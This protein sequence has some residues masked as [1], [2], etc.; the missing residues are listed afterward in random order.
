MVRIA[1]KD[2][3]VQV[4]VGGKTVEPTHYRYEAGTIRL[5][6][7]NSTENLPVEIHF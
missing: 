7:P 2:K 5:Q 4:L 6:F 3:P 1:S